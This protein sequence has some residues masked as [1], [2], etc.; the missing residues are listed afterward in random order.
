MKN[1]CEEINPFRGFRE[2]NKYVDKQYY[3]DCVYVKGLKWLHEKEVWDI[4]QMFSE[5]ISIYYAKNNKFYFIHVSTPT[6]VVQIVISLGH[7]FHIEKVQIRQGLP[8]T[9]SFIHFFKKHARKR[10]RVSAKTHEMVPR[11]G[12]SS[13]F[14][15]DMT[16][17]PDQQSSHYYLPS[18]LEHEL[19]SFFSKPLFH[20]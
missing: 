15:E 6:D 10:G 13:F 17:E 19:F 4:F 1:W 20:K 18:Y 3:Q 2:L 7:L 9:S 5:I 11:G 14:A 12:W 16:D 8:T